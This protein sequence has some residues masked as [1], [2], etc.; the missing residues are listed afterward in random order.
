[1]TVL[2]WREE[3]SLAGATWISA[4]QFYKFSLQWVRKDSPLLRLTQAHVQKRRRPAQR[5]VAQL[6][7]VFYGRGANTTIKIK[8]ERYGR[9][10]VPELR[11]A[12]QNLTLHVVEI[13]TEIKSTRRK[14]RL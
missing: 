14:S 8:L 2:A 5:S 1:M 6:A 4:E 10:S 11:N 12:S 3:S 7:C 13:L 9:K